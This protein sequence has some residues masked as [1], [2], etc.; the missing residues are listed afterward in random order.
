NAAT[1][2]HLSTLSQYFIPLGNFILPIIIWT[3]LKKDSAFV[4]S[5]GRNAINFQLS[6]FLYTI[7]LF[8]IAIPVFLYSIFSNLDTKSIVIDDDFFF[9]NL[10]SGNWTG[11]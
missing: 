1:I 3:S 6:I 5:H 4:E 10:V 7:I 8:L 9:N 11:I 2:I